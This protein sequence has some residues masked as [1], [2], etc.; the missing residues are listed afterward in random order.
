MEID[1]RLDKDSLSIP[2]ENPF[3]LDLDAVV[4]KIEVFISSKGARL[5][6]LDVKGLLPRMVRGV[7]GC[8]DG[9]PANALDFVDNGFRNFDLEYIEGGIL[10]AKGLLENGAVL[11]IKMFPD[12]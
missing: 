6:G 3:H 7:A 12:F 9:C 8:E 4:G 5:N 1:V 2:V 10:S 11:S